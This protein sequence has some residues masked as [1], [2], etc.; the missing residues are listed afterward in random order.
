MVKS[1]TVDT[2]ARD[3]TSFARDS[4]SNCLV[5]SNCFEQIALFNYP[6][7]NLTHV[8]FVLPW[9]NEAIIKMWNN[10]NQCSLK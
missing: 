3:T 6:L 5:S 4:P 8:L 7:D 1:L 2:E 9:A 10:S